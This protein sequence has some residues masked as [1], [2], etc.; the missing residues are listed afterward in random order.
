M[1]GL[2]VYLSLFSCSQRGTTAVLVA[3]AGGHLA[4]VRE[5]VEQHRADLLHKANVSSASCILLCVIQ[6]VSH[7]CHVYWP[8]LWSIH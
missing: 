4:L 3:A 2:I 6:I 1:H 5:L 7:F 8:S